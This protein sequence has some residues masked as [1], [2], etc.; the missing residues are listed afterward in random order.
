MTTI[1]D[2]KDINRIVKEYF[3]QLYAYKY[4]ELDNIELFFERHNPSKFTKGKID[5]LN[6]MISIK[7]IE[8]RINNFPRQKV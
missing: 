2:P 4:D 7:E 6:K 3:E 5:N 1:I 8:S